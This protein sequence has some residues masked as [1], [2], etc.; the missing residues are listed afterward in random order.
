MK[1]KEEIELKLSELRND[2][3]LE[4]RNGSQDHASDRAKQLHGEIM[5]LLWVLGIL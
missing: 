5:S 1:T 3:D 2:Y 4:L